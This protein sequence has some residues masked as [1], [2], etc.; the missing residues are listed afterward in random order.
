[1]SSSLQFRRLQSCLAC[2]SFTVS[3]SLLKSMSMESVMLSNNL[4]L[5][6]PLLHLL[7]IFPSFRVYSNELTFHIRWPKYWSFSFSI[8]PSNEYSGFIAFK[9]DCFDLL[10]V[11]G[12]L[13]GLLRTT[14]RKCQFFGAQPSLWSHSH[15][16]AWLM[17]KSLLW[18]YTSNREIYIYIHI[19][20]YTYIYI[21]THTSPYWGKYLQSH[22]TNTGKSLEQQS[23]I[24]K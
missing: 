19:Y 24:P 11:Q 9:I 2:L 5:C 22:S 6:H 3:W 7:S 1:M 14:V 4:I 12:T 10:A 17:E 23:G 21:H 13:K 8:S 18:L 16:H 15:I 20:I